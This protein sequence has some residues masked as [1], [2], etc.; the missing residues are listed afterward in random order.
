MKKL[1]SIYLILMLILLI[2]SNSQ[3]LSESSI[4]KVKQATSNLDTSG[5]VNNPILGMD[6]WETPK[7]YKGNSIDWTVEFEKEE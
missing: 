1:S 5:K 4:I 3:D 2:C 6:F 7:I